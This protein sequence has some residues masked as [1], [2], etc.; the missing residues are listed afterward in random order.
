[1]HTSPLEKKLPLFSYK[2]RYKT[3]NISSFENSNRSALCASFSIHTLLLYLDFKNPKWV[4]KLTVMDIG[5]TNDHKDN[6]NHGGEFA[7]KNSISSDKYENQ[8]VASQQ[9]SF[10][11]KS[12]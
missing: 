2:R 10:S 8:N 7:P 1:M 3:S 11:Q 9:L 5:R 4:R 6:L 12:N